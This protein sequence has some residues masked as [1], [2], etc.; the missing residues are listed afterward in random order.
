MLPSTLTAL[1]RSTN[2]L[3]NYRIDVIDSKLDFGDYLSPDAPHA[4]VIERKKNLRELCGNLLIPHKRRNFVLELERLQERSCF[5]WLLLEGDIADIDSG[6]GDNVK[7]M[8]ARDILLDLLH[9]HRV[10][11]ACMRS[12]T[13]KQRAAVGRWVAATI[14]SGV[15]NGDHQ[16]C[17][18]F[19]RS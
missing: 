6:P 13:T 8:K 1:D 14:L 11:F 18:G 10:S 2:T 4:V 7:N 15:I 12:S 3:A 16:C 19:P 5:P 17:D 9:T